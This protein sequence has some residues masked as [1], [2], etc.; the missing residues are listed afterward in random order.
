MLWNFSDFSYRKNAAVE[1]STFY[2]CAF[3]TILIIVAADIMW[4]PYLLER[5]RMD[6]YFLMG[7][8]CF[9]VTGL[10][11]SRCTVKQRQYLNFGLLVLSGMT[12]ISAFLFYVYTIGNDVHGVVSVIADF[13]H[14]L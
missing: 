1:N 9:I 5:Y 11:Q 7:I 14:L 13:L 2:D 10:W 6:I 12:I 3:L 4:S 8:G